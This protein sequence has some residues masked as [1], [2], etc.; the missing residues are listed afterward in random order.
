[1]TNDKSDTQSRRSVLR[2]AGA[3][4]AT[5]ATATIGV[6][7]SASAESDIETLRGGILSAT[8]EPDE[9]DWRSLALGFSKRYRGG[10]GAPPNAETLAERMSNEFVANED[11]WVQYGNWLLDETGA[12]G[13]GDA[14][15][16]V[17]VS[18]TRTRWPTRSETVETVIDTEYD[19][20]LDEFQSVDWRIESAEEP[21]YHV[22]IR[23]GAAENAADEL[24]QFRREHIDE[25]EGE[26]DLPS[27]QYVS[28]V[29]GRYLVNIGFGDETRS[30]LE[31]FLGDVDGV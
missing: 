29:A 12:S 30:V 23:N 18:I 13:I 19:D 24:Q 9:I 11:A 28:E 17:D 6:P 7:S 8:L 4:I 31:L 27:D 14:Q 21:D 5:A 22:E 26:H 3:G 20:D 2:A 16:A 10:Y 15:V 1:M 25:E